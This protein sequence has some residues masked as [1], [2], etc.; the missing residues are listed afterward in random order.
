[1]THLLL[2]PLVKQAQPHIN[3]GRLLQVFDKD[4]MD[5]VRQTMNH[6]DIA[7]DVQVGTFMTHARCHASLRDILEF[8]V[9]REIWRCVS[10][11]M[12]LGN[13]AYAKTTGS[14]D[15]MIYVCKWNS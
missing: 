3:C 14:N 4:E 2:V 15:G 1:L 7:A 8:V 11:V 9:Q 5:L 13:V 6:V 10:A 12:A